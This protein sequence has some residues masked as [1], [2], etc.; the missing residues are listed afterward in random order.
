MMTATN[1]LSMMKEQRKMKDTKYMYDTSDPQV[2]SGSIS[3]PVAFLSYAL[4]SQGR[5][6]KPASMIS[7]QA[8]PVAHLKIKTFLYKYLK[9]LE[10]STSVP[11]FS[12]IK[13]GKVLLKKEEER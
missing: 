13:D 4:S 9:L 5:P 12:L 1:K 10:Y 3:C 7:G 8:S 2:W 11:I 6:D